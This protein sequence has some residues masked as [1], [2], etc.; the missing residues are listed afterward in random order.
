M[1]TH[2]KRL[3]LAN[4]LHHSVDLDSATFRYCVVRPPFPLV[5]SKEGSNGRGEASCSET[6]QPRVGVRDRLLQ[7]CRHDETY[8]RAR[9]PGGFRY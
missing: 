8:H 3:V 2:R 1:S 9:D 5:A 4:S 6:D 7:H